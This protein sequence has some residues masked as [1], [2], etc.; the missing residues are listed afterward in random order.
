M[1]LFV[2]YSIIFFCF[3]LLSCK[4]EKE[5]KSDTSEISDLSKNNLNISILID[6]SDRISPTKY[7]NPT[8]DFYQ[9]D[10]GYINSIANE[11]NNHIQT[12]RVRQIDDKIQIFFDPEPLN[13]EINSISKKMKLKFDKNNVDK[14]KLNAIKEIYN[15][16]SKKI[17][18][19]AIN[20]DAYVG[21]DIWKFF[22]NNVNDYCIDKNYRNVLVILTDGYMYHKDSKL[23]EGNRTSYITPSVISK[24][25]LDTKEW[26]SDIK[27]KDYGFIS[28]NNDL[29]NLEI[30]VLGINPSTNNPYEEDV[31]KKYWENWFKEMKVKKFD[32]KTTNLPSNM[33]III[34]DFIND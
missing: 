21:S 27:S 9:R 31:L 17:Y 5:E 28:A 19:L 22:K 14:E 10:L 20:D 18:N 11:F 30:L 29:S 25:K 24:Y 7:P 32:I 23:V 16:E 6:L 4:N 33:D 3:S 26:E 2:K 13:P 12:K 34:K 8:M 1:K 15:N